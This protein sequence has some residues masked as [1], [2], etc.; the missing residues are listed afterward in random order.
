[1]RIEHSDLKRRRVFVE[2]IPSSDLK[3]ASLHHIQTADLN[4][5]QVLGRI[6]ASD[7]NPVNIIRALKTSSYL[8]TVYGLCAPA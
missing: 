3:T 1:M 5:T 8:D 7:L 4:A 2:Y 6:D